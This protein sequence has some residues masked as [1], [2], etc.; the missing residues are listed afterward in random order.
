[1]LHA[2]SVP[3]LSFQLKTVSGLVELCLVGAKLERS[4]ND[5]VES[6]KCQLV[7]RNKDGCVILRQSSVCNYT[8]FPQWNETV[9][10][11][12][13]FDAEIEFSV[14]VNMM[15]GNVNVLKTDKYLIQDLGSEALQL[16][17]GLQY[18]GELFLTT[19]LQP[20]CFSFK[21]LSIGCNLSRP[22][23]FTLLNNILNLLQPEDA[24]DS[25]VDSSVEE[26]K[27][28]IIASVDQLITFLTE[29]D[30]FQEQL[31][32][33]LQVHASQL[34]SSFKAM[35]GIQNECNSSANESPIRGVLLSSVPVHKVAVG[36]KY[37]VASLL[38]GVNQVPVPHRCNPSYNNSQLCLFLNITFYLMFLICPGSSY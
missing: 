3:F 16:K 23:S 21:Y 34:K 33:S 5:T 20:N 7:V 8:S 9:K 27:I 25:V 4:F 37:F 11:T 17:L 18:V 22:L 26:E 29:E 24:S 1:M 38:A 14:V 15:N 35:N 13:S 31:K 36:T 30:V 2:F 12:S 32:F 19:V 28:A 10:L 6:L